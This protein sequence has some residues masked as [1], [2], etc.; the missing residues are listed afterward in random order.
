M[1]HN[2]K[3]YLIIP[4][5]FCISIQFSLIVRSVAT[6]QIEVSTKKASDFVNS[7]GVEVRLY[8][9]QRSSLWT[10]ILK[11][12]LQELG[13][14]HIRTNISAAGVSIDSNSR[15]K[16]VADRIQELGNLNRPIKTTGIL[17]EFGNWISK[18]RAIQYLENSLEAIEGPN[19][20]NRRGEGF[21]YIDQEGI[22]H[23]NYDVYGSGN[24]IKVGRGWIHGVR[25]FMED[26]HFYVKKYS[27]LDIISFSPTK[28]GYDKVNQYQK[29]NN[30][31]LEDWIDYG[32]LHLYRQ[33]EPER[34]IPLKKA[35]ATM[36][37]TKP[38]VVTETGYSTSK[39]HWPY[40]P[41]EEIQATY[42]LRSL[43]EL[44]NLGVKR[45]YI[46]SLLRF[47]QGRYFSLLDPDDLD[48]PVYEPKM[49]FNAVRDTISLLEENRSDFIP[50]RLDYQII[51]KPYKRN[52]NN[53]HSLVLQKSDN[54]FYIIL[55]LAVPY[56]ASNLERTFD[57]QLKTPGFIKANFYQP[58]Q[59]GTKIVKEIFDLYH[60]QQLTISDKPLII[61]LIPQF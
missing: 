56:D 12:R 14:R 43:L 11:P 4:L 61:E 13:V 8:P 48:N 50:K 2:R 7:I 40:V 49:S 34:G 39:Q 41:N 47:K 6:E 37:P 20:P 31:H 51:N 26:L 22:R 53:Y 38:I 42:N 1:K 36:Y 45:T 17:R 27:N 32:N 29:D 10:E 28:G 18:M 3:Y 55:W 57:F 54:K 21:D 60:V 5:L 30:W 33:S 24:K 44:F 59:N 35:R 19:E 15:G 16:I 23:G 46:F 58:I 52:Q 9:E 25:L